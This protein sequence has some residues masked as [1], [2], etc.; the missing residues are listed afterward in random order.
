MERRA[1][2]FVG[3]IAGLVLVGAGVARAGDRSFSV[4]VALESATMVAGKTLQP[5]DYTFSWTGNGPQV[6]VAVKQDGKIVEE[7]KAKIVDQ[8]TRAE[9]QSMVT[10]KA[11]SGAPILEELRV[12]GERT[13]LMFTS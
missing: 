2:A 9:E 4:D 13:A 12:R 1:G 7:A 8:A 6:E 11:Q 5:G 10:R 3:L